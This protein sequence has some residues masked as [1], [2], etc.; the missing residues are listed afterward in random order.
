MSGNPLR[1]SLLVVCLPLVA[2]AGGCAV[3]TDVVNP[4]L[5]SALGLDPATV[6]PSPGRLIVAC[7]N[8][9]QYATE[10]TFVATSAPLASATVADL[11]PGWARVEAGETALSPFDCPV[12]NLVLGGLN[13]DYSLSDTA[14]TV[15]TDGAD[16]AVVYSGAMLE[17]G[18][19]FA[20]GDV[21]EVR[22]VQTGGEAGT[23]DFAIQVRIVPGR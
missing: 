19:D 1:I 20:C 7:V 6:I 12:V 14:V 17:V 16:I 10:F 23:E 2:L 13:E 4:N 8:D 22:L 15:T 9:T 18:R 3:A 11:T 5:L 21:I